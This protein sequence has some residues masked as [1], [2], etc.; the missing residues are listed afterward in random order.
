VSIDL[1]QARALADTA[2]ESP[3]NGP[4]A[5]HLAATVT[6]LAA[7][8]EETRQYLADWRGAALK[9]ERERDEL[10][11]MIE[12]HRRLRVTSRSL[13]SL[14]DP[15]TH[16]PAR[17]R[18]WLAANGWTLKAQHPK[19]S[20]WFNPALTRHGWDREGSQVLVLDWT[21]FSDY[22]DRLATTVTDLA[23]LHGLGE[24]AVLAGI[25]CADV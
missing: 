16:S 2:L 21:G 7:E 4:E 25:E 15:V 23:G 19:A 14:I 24:L 9:T 5:R 10:A 20:E 22:A 18:A 11:A 1:K 6:A 12:T 17:V 8:L 13:E 3:S